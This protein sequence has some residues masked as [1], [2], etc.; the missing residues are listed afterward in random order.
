MAAVRNKQKLVAL[1]KEN[2]EEQTRGNQAWDAKVPRAQE[3]YIT[4]VTEKTEGRV[5]EKLSQGFSKTECRILGA[6]SRLDDFLLNP[7]L[8]GHS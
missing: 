8:Q 5:T 2:H 4:Q 1:N 7:L 3:D 6:R